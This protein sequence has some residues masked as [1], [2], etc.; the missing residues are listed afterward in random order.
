MA[1]DGVQDIVAI[2]VKATPTF[3]RRFLRG[4]KAIG[5][6]P[7]IRRR[8]LLYLGDRSLRTKE[9]IEVVTMARFL[10]MLH[11]GRLMVK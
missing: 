8:L 7:G 4:L 11:T 1:T 10:E 6:L 2:E 5:E 9:G 3:Q